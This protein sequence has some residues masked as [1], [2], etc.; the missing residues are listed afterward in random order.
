MRYFQKPLPEDTLKLLVLKGVD[1][2]KRNV[3]PRHAKGDPAV[4][5]RDL[6]APL[7][8]LFIQSLIGDGTFL[9]LDNGL[10]PRLIK[11]YAALGIHMQLDAIAIMPLLRRGK[12]FKDRRIRDPCNARQRFPQ[13]LPFPSKL[14]VIG[15]MLPLAP[16][17][18]AK[19]RTAG[20]NAIG[21]RM[22]DRADRRLRPA[23]VI[24]CHLNIEDIARGGVRNKDLLP[25]S[26]TKSR[27]SVDEF[28][29]GHATVLAHDKDMKQRG[30]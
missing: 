24:L 22:D 13:N 2:G 4:A 14:R 26:D 11:P 3:V 28:L 29:D 19:D 25:R 16:A 12:R 27:P 6:G 18:A 8:E 23:A 10:R 15:E 20:R 1:L 9:E 17:A 30:R 7:T 21:G 5:C